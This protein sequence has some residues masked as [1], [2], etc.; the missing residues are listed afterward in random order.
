MYLEPSSSHPNHVFSGLFKGEAIRFVR[1]CSQESD[2][3][4]KLQHF[5]TKLQARGHLLPHILKHTQ[6]INFSSRPAFLSPKNKLVSPSH[7][8]HPPFSTSTPLVISTVYDPHL[9]HLKSV[10]LKHWHFIQNNT[11]L[12]TLFPT[13]PIVAYKRGPNISD[14]LIRSR[15]SPLRPTTS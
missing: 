11:T 13:P 8:P 1:N 10:F 3:L 4:S 7:Q 12:A 14:Q 6:T 15:L 2:F 9:V 5:I